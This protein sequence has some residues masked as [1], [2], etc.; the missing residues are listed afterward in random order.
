MSGT[1]PTGDHPIS[2]VNPVAY[3]VTNEQR[4]GDLS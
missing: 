4:K 3:P 2:F 1:T